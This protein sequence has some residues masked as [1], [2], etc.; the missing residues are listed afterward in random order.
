MELRGAKTQ[1]DTSIIVNNL[2]TSYIFFL[3][4]SNLCKCYKTFLFMQLSCKCV[5][6]HIQ[7]HI[8]I[9]THCEY[10]KYKHGINTLKHVYLHLFLRINIPNIHTNLSVTVSLPIHMQYLHILRHH[11]ICIILQICVLL[12]VCA[13][14]LYT[15]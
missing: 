2:R 15:L 14:D 4:F 5:Y 12:Q 9:Y 10:D 3:C 8:I 6:M 1:D 13:G 7:A 11:C